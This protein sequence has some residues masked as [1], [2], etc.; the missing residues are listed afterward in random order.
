MG[1][2]R[3]L[4]RD[5]LLELRF[6]LDRNLQFVVVGSIEQWYHSRHS[7]ANNRETRACLVL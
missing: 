7:R 6:A 5:G 2:N 1:G 4:K 3:E